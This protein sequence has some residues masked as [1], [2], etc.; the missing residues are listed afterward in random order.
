M[1]HFCSADHRYVLVVSIQGQCWNGLIEA[2]G[3]GYHLAGDSPSIKH[4]TLG[5]LVEYYTCR[6]LPFA[7]TKNGD[8]ETS[9]LVT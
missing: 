4:A 1:I 2:V 7:A 3:N 5:E 9:T 6:P 8:Y